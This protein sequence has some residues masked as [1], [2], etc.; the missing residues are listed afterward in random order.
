MA[1]T[2]GSDFAPHNMEANN[3]PAPFVTLGSTEYFACPAYYA[4]EGTTYNVWLTDGVST[5]WLRLDIGS[6]NAKKLYSYAIAVNSAPSQPERAPK[7]WIVQGSNNGSTWTD[8]NTQTNQTSWGSGETREF[9]LDQAYMATAYRYFRLNV[10]ANN[11][12]DYLQCGELYLYEAEILALGSLL[13][14]Q[15]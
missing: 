11:G 13:S 2:K 10:S 8:L 14:F 7:N 9:T 15:W 4:F 3:N 5:G 6:G 12:D 1:Y